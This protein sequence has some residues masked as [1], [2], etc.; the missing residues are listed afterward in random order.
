MFVSSTAPI[1]IP[2]HFVDC[3]FVAFCLGRLTVEIVIRP[4]A[5]F[6]RFAF[7]GTFF[8]RFYPGHGSLLPQVQQTECRHLNPIQSLIP[9]T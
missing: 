8:F 6:L 7:C 4:A 2:Q 1:L 3:P 9:A 5:A